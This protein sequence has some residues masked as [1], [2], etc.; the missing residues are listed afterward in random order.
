MSQPGFTVDVYQNE[1]LPEG[2]REVNAIVTVTSPGTAPD[3][4]RQA[5]RPT[6][7]III[8]DCSGSMDTR[9]PRSPRPAR[10]P[11]PPSTRSA[12]GW[13]SPWSPA[14]TGAQPVFPR[15]APGHRQPA[16]R[17]GGQAGRGPAAA[18]GGTAIGQWLAWPTRCSPRARPT[19]RHA[20]LLTDG[21]NEHE[22]P[23]ELA[24]AIRLCEG[25]FTCDCRGVGTDWEV[26][27]LRRIS[28][29]LLGTVDIVR[30]P[31]RP[32]RRLRGR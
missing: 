24:A 4:G 27:E 18:G 7:E 10:P 30:R 23:A 11:R 8:V 28:T 19:L 2:G 13:R 5:A 9:R 21:K 17:R 32:G 1:Y 14:P 31:G 25:Q 12:T 15:T 3:G 6:R 22:N 16:T 20:I 29:A 26:A